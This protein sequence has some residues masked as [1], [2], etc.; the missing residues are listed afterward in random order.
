[1]FVASLPCVFGRERIEGA[2]RGDLQSGN[3]VA[4]VWRA[5]ASPLRSR[6]TMN[7]R[8]FVKTL[9]AGV[10]GVAANGLPS[11]V[12]AAQPA[13]E[14]AA[15]KE[16]ER[17]M[18][19]IWMT[20]GPEFAPDSAA[21]PPTPPDEWKRTFAKMRANNIHG[22]L[23]EI[24]DGR[25]AHYASS[26]LPR[27]DDWLGTILPLA[28]AE[29]LE[30]HAWMVSM[31]VNV[32]ELWAQH[33]EW[34][35]VNRKGESSVDKPAYV[36]YYRFTCPN[37]PGAQDF[38]AKRVEEICSV[39]GLDGIHFDYIRHPDVI[40]AQALQPKYGIVQDREYPE[41]D[42][43]YCDVCR[44]MCRKQYG[45]DPMQ[46]KDPA[47]SP[48]WREFRYDSITNLVNRRLI[49]IARKKGKKTSAA[50]FPNWE[51]VRQRWHHW[52]LD[53]V[54]PMLYHQF[55]Y[56]DATWVRDH[57]RAGIDRLR[58]H[59]KHA[60]LFSGL[61]VNE[62]YPA[63][64]TRLVEKAYEGGARGVCLFSLRQMNDRLWAAFKDAT[65]GAA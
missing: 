5:A 23:P 28:K 29:G 1:M 36:D 48:E 18:N 31:P 10:V 60:Q 39:D 11:A 35:D 24:W 62:L 2:R 56:G 33:K 16:P 32:P 22:I 42:Y 27:A 21:P 12:E 40:I 45:F 17:V 15:R 9:G 63:G 50:T 30:V 41:Y 3:Y 61:F 52:D 55:Y 13:A 20:P 51:A 59:R 8:E 57:T 43:C 54:H 46:L 44:D 47:V 26:F 19:W 6:D 14:A 38:I 4:Y 37:Q 58:E 25:K 64:L 7:K 49:P 65:A 34:F 53:Y